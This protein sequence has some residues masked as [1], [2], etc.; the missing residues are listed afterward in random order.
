[1]RQWW[2]VPGN[3]G[4]VSELRDVPVPQP[5]SG[6]VLVRIE[7]T[8]INRG[9]LIARPRLVSSNPKAAPSEPWTDWSR[10]NRR[11]FDK[12]AGEVM[13]RLGYGD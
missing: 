12:Q 11:E 6:E 4:G 5:G 10:S 1:M 7:A 3:D 9:E 8:A 2:V 13:K